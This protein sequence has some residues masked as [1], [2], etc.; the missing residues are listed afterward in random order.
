MKGFIK[1]KPGLPHFN[2]AAQVCEKFLGYVFEVPEEIVKMRDGITAASTTSPSSVC[3]ACHKILTPL[4][5][6]RT[7]WTDDGVYKEKDAQG[8]VIDDSDQNLVASYPFKG[9]GMEAFA[10]QA[11][12]KE[13][14]LRTIFQ[15]HFVFYFGREMR[16][17]KDERGLYKRLWDSAKA[18]SYS[19]KSL[20]RTLLTSPEYLD[21]VRAPAAPPI[22]PKRAPAAKPQ[23][24]AQRT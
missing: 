6:Q 15:T 9:R 1:G 7:R 8:R 23:H 24:L 20:I 21:G 16:Y 17:D 5:Y 14:F 4:A 10:T 13:R 19:L 22:I 3:Y 12:N 2:Y 18:S 11:Q